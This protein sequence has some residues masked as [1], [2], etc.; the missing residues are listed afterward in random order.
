M[1]AIS[2]FLPPRFIQDCIECGCDVGDVLSE[3]P[4]GKTLLRST[5]EQYAEL[6]S[7]AELYTDP[8]GPDACPPGLKTAARTLLK[9]MDDLAEACAA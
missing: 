7:R 6:R 4:K 1:T 9:A 8:N 5:P 2:R 3:K